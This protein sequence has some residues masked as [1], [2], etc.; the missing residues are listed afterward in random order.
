MKA[1]C[2]DKTGTLPTGEPTVVSFLP[3]TDTPPDDRQLLAAAAGLAAASTHALSRS[4]V[5]L[6]RSRGVAPADIADARTIPGRG[7]VGRCGNT[8]VRLGSVALM[9]ESSLT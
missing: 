8:T 7:L 2:L 6:A 4:V 9:E 5:A 1:V 3:R